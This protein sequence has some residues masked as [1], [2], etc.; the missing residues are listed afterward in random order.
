MHCVKKEKH[1]ILQ[2]KYIRAFFRSPILEIKM[3]SV[4]F[5]YI[6]TMTLVLMSTGRLI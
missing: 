4:D 2:R 1:P 3:M 5:P 6:E